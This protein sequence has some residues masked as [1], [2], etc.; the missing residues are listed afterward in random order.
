M[1]LLAH[2]AIKP[3]IL[4]LSLAATKGTCFLKFYKYKRIFLLAKVINGSTVFF[5]YTNVHKVS[6]SSCIIFIFIFAILDYTAERFLGYQSRPLENSWL[7]NIIRIQKALYC[8]ECLDFPVFIILI[9]FWH[10]FS[11]IS[12][13]EITIFLPTINKMSGAFVNKIKAILIKNLQCKT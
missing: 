12:L 9:L 4:P 11:V 3:W 1:L 5:K 2:Y 10:H 6:S 8:L 7:Q 13:K